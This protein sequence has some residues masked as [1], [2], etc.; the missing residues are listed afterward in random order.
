LPTVSG[1][2]LKRTRTVEA[3]YPASAQSRK[4]SGWVE[5]VFTVNEKGRVEDAEVRSSSPE[6]IFDEAAVRALRQWRYEPPLKDGQP[7][8]VRTMVRLKFEPPK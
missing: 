2:T 1:S 5:V 7:T 6:E 3:E 8:A 4:I